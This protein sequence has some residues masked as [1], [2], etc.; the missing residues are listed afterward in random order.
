MNAKVLQLTGDIDIAYLGPPLEEG[1]LPAI[2]YFAL[3][4]EES[5]SLDPYNQPAVYLANFPVRIFSFDL[6]AH[7]AGLNAIDAIKVW[8]QGFAQGEDPLVPFLDKVTR[9][10]DMLLEKRL[11]T[12]EKIGFMGL[13][14]GGLISSLVAT[15]FPSVRALVHFAP[16]TKLT[17][18]KEFEELKEN[19]AAIQ[20]DLQNYL[21]ALC[22][23]KMRIYIGNRD[24][25]VGTDLATKWALNLANT[26]FENGERSPPVE[27]TL[28]P[29][30]GHMG[31]GTSKETFEA[32]AEWLGKTL[33]I[34]R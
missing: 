3:S 28:T 30:I 14:R 1:P 11:L 4:A 15:R 23:K 9:A 33:G 19:D 25:R 20:Y 34:I 16:L 27:L 26:G 6:P 5:L 18:A 24:T 31:H 12:R 8:A 22:D 2:F 32:G 29:S 7:G 21:P 13:S 10:L 17:N